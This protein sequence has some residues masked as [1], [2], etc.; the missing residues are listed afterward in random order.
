MPLRII[1]LA[2]VLALGVRAEERVVSGTLL[3]EIDTWAALAIDDVVKAGKPL[4]Q[5][6]TK[7]AMKD[8]TIRSFQ[9]FLMVTKAEEEKFARGE[10]D[11]E[12][13]KR[14]MD[15]QIDAFKQADAKLPLFSE[16]SIASYKKGELKG[17]KLEL[18][19]RMNMLLY[20]KLRDSLQPDKK[21][22]PPESKEPK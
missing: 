8:Q 19:V 6:V 7:E 15:A 13:N 12:K 16:Q 3:Q 4:P 11:D 18:A 14:L 22:V 9:P 20:V 10:F 5:G 17:G 21:P 2:L 1:V